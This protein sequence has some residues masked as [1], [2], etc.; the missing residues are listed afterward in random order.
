MAPPNLA[1]WPDRCLDSG[2]FQED[3]KKRLHI[4]QREE[5]LGVY[6]LQNQQVPYLEGARL[7]RG[8]NRSRPIHKKNFRPFP[9][10]D[11]DLGAHFCPAHNN[12]V[13]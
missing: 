5:R 12:Y 9:P 3:V 7:Q 8:E 11:N 2:Q 4:R 6:R 13:F 1:I 10:N